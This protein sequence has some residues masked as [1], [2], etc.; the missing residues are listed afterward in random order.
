MPPPCAELVGAR[1]VRCGAL[2]RC[3]QRYD[4]LATR[5]GRGREVLG[6]TDAA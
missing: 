5:I 6:T 1:H 2:V 3:R 4:A